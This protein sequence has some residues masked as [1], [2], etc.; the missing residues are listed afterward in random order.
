MEFQYSLLF[1]GSFCYIL[2]GIKKKAATLYGVFVGM[3]D[4]KITKNNAGKYIENI[5]IKSL[6]IIERKRAFFFDETQCVQFEK[7]VRKRVK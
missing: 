4:F 2:F 1:A 6:P 3:Y 7:I 5:Y